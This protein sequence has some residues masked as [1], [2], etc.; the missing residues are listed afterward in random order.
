[1][2]LSA[3]SF[4]HKERRDYIVVKVSQSYFIPQKNGDVLTGHKM[5]E[6]KVAKPTIS[7]LR[8]AL[9]NKNL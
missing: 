6:I 3:I 2:K 8:K 5:T 9:K 4:E 1:M 7:Q